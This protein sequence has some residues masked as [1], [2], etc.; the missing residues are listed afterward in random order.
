MPKEFSRKTGI[1]VV[2]AAKEHLSYAEEICQVIN[3]EAKKRKTGI[4]K[5]EPEY[6]Q[7]KIFEGKAVIAL[8]ESGKFAGFCYIESWGK[9]KDYIANSGLIVA[10]E[11]RELGLGKVIKK[12][13]FELSH[14]M[15]PDA[16][17]F[18]IT[19]SPAVMKINYN[20]GYR[21][22]VFKQL[23]DDEEFWAGCKGCVN[24]DI[25]VRT[26]HHHCLCTAMLFDPAEKNKK[27]KRE[28]I[29]EEKSSIGV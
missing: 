8:T 4:A 7:Q 1:H 20:L 28:M 6:I 25:L 17:L 16:K 19:T 26:N 13:A 21:P 10:S 18:G 24:Y 22:V 14:Q 23:T 5:R 3:E 29:N 9:N 12:A 2:A 15:F 11:F 27:N